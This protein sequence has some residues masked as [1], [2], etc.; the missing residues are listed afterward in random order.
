MSSLEG[1]FT[2]NSK[3][4]AKKYAN[5]KIKSYTVGRTPIQEFIGKYISGKYKNLPYDKLFHLFI[6][7]ELDPSQD[8]A[9]SGAVA[10]STAVIFI[11]T[12][13]NPDT[14]FKK[15]DGNVID[16][17]GAESFLVPLVYNPPTYGEF[18]ENLRKLQGKR[19][20]QYD[21]LKNNCQDYVLDCVN[22]LYG[23][24]NREFT[25]LS[26]DDRGDTG[27]NPEI[28]A[29]IKQDVSDIFYGADFKF[30]KFITDTYGS[31]KSFFGG[32]S[33]PVAGR[34]SVAPKGG[35]IGLPFDPRYSYHDPT[36]T[37]VDI[38]SR[39]FRDSK[40]LSDRSR[41]AVTADGYGNPTTG[42]FDRAKYT[43]ITKNLETGEEGVRW[44][45]H[46]GGLSLH[47][48]APEATKKIDLAHYYPRQDGPVASPGG[49]LGKWHWV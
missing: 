2:D 31:I 34:Y 29:F 36:V 35:L 44:K 37:G 19:F 11:L 17:R 45:K 3:S 4:F 1:G 27:A 10:T 16:N 26:Y 46:K 7:L 21:A 14:I 13:K 39:R 28:I 43:G 32:T 33:V 23:L 47:W 5:T 30:A 9:Q 18:I 15:V 42:G 22:A 40:M 48:R 12:E 20:N 6:I 41:G 38:A 25:G 8:A 49:S 24:T